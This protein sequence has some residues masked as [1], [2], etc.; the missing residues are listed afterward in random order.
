MLGD[1]K[2]VQGEDLIINRHVTK[3]EQHLNKRNKTTS[4]QTQE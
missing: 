4:K 1:G 2:Q 3:Q